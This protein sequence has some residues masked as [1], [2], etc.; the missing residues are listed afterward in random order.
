VSQKA[1]DGLMSYVRDQ[2]LKTAEKNIVSLRK[3]YADR[4]DLVDNEQIIQQYVRDLVDIIRPGTRIEP[5]FDS[6]IIFEAVS[7]RPDLKVDLMLTINRNSRL[8]P[9]FFTNTSSIPIAWLDERAGLEGRVMGVHFYNPPAVQKLVEVIKTDTTN[10]ELSYFVTE[11]I[12]N[13]GKVAVPSYDVAGFIGN[14]YFMRDILYAE[15]VVSQLQGQFS[16]PETIYMMNKISQ[17]YL[18]RPMGIFQ[19]CDYVG[20]DVVKF[21]MSVMDSYIDKETI[22]SSLVEKMLAHDAKG[23]QNPDGSQKDGFFSYSKGKI[24]GIYDL[25][26]KRY[27]GIEDPSVLVNEHLGPMPTSWMPWKQMVRHPHKGSL[28]GVYFDELKTKTNPGAIMALDYLKRFREIGMNLVKD[29][30][31]FKFDDVN[32][33]LVYGFHHAYGPVTDYF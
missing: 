8:H 22:Q 17:D 27:V 11:F 26:K 14:G 2:A 6:R 4:Q 9:W 21:I 1:L 29:K 19:L 32:A 12:K 33:V 23:G 13:T 5:S 10:P 18:I 7:E 20:L 16:F 28:L 3:A 25:G 24:T 31:A 30:I 15:K